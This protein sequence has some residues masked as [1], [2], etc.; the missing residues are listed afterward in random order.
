VVSPGAI[1]F[2]RGCGL[3]GVCSGVG[4]LLMLSSPRPAVV[5][6]EWKGMAPP[7]SSLGLFVV[8][9]GMRLSCLD[10]SFG[11]PWWRGEEVARRGVGGWDLLLGDLGLEVLLGLPHLLPARWSGKGS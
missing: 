1:D 2:Q 9:L 6:R 10:A 11:R 4:G 5:V 8:F 3:S 7:P